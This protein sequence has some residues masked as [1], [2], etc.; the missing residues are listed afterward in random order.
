MR[1]SCPDIYAS[2]RSQVRT[3]GVIL[4]C[5][6]LFDKPGRSFVFLVFLLFFQL[7]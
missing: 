1:V 3:N 2:Q 4:A 6:Q 5:M 7:K